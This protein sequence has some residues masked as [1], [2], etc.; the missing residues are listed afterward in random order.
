MT[1]STAVQKSA[2]GDLEWQ[3]A[4]RIRSFSKLQ[5]GWHYGS[6]I[7]A[8]TCAIDGALSISSLL[9]DYGARNIEAFP[10]LD[11]GILVSGYHIRDSLEILC[12]PDGRIDFAHDVDDE[13]ISEQPNVS[14][15]TIESYLGE[16]E[17]RKKSLFVSYTRSTTA[18]NK[19]DLRAWLSNLRLTM[20]EY[21]YSTHNVVSKWGD[22]NVAISIVS[23]RALPPIPIFS[24][25]STLLSFQ[26]SAGLPASHR[27]RAIPATEI[28]GNCPIVDAG[29]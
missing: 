12:R 11:G 24:G 5:D 26:K 21:R 25:E 20:E 15:E 23:T 8:V 18:E 13:R 1:D 6:G 14:Q 7:G 2:A 28:F 29:R 16:L 4:E 10:D 9:V 22:A 27:L 19:D 3:I 17:W